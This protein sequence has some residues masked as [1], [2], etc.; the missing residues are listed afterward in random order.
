MQLLSN[1]KSVESLSCLNRYLMQAVKELSTQASKM[2]LLQLIVTDKRGYPHN[3]FLIS[4]RI[5]V[6]G[7]H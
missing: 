4:Q 2:F 7:T 5:H 1:S 6:V 3:I